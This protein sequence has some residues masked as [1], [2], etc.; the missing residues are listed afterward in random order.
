M[1][2][3]ID[4]QLKNRDAVLAQIAANGQVYVEDVTIDLDEADVPQTCYFLVEDAPP[5]QPDLLAEADARILELEY[6][7]LM[8]KEGLT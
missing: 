2:N 1:V 6:E 5:A 3:R 8:Q 7:N 4:Y